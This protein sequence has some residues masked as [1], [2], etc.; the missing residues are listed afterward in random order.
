MTAAA[1]NGFRPTFRLPMFEGPLD[2]LL[3][4]IREN[5]V[6]IY[7]I[8]IA[9]ITRQYLE[10]LAEW[11]SL[12]LTVAGDYLVMAATLLEIKS[13]MLLPR[14]PAPEQ[15]EQDPRA[16]LV[17]RLLEY[18]RY[19]QAV[20]TLRTWE[21]FRQQLHFRTQEANGEDYAIPVVAT[22]L[23]PADLARA[24]RRLLE[25][26]G[27]QPTETVSAIVPHEKVSLKLKMAEIL[28]ALRHRPEGLSFAD[29]VMSATDRR[30][31]VI[32]FLALLELLRRGRVRVIQRAS[33]GA[34]RILRP[35]AEESPT[36]V[37]DH[38]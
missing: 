28:N 6:D 15:E 13:R 18:Q 21:A 24:L 20:E 10:K 31:V 35:K 29:L 27:V 3:H 25:N 36:V 8:P 9:E 16:E 37:R 33:C 12:D 26:A 11:Q 32:A 2:L 22:E 4:L 34:I 5:E 14:P 30:E 38:A 17:Q 7:D 23:E 1:G 19:V